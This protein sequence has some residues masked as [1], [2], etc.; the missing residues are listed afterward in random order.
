MAPLGRDAVIRLAVEMEEEQLRLDEEEARANGFAC[1]ED[2][3]RSET[4]KLLMLHEQMIADHCAA[5]GQTRE[6]ADAVLWHQNESPD[7]SLPPCQDHEHPFE[8]FCPHSL[9]D[10]RSQDNPGQI[11]FSRFQNRLNPEEL[12]IKE[13]DKS[14][15]LD[16]E[17]LEKY[18]TRDSPKTPRKIPFW[19]SAEG[20][21][22]YNFHQDTRPIP[23]TSPS[24]SLSQTPGLL[25]DEPTGSPLSAEDITMTSTSTSS[26]SDPGHSARYAREIPS[27]ESSILAPANSHRRNLGRKAQVRQ[28]RKPHPKTT[29]RVTSRPQSSSSGITKARWGPAMGLR[30]RT[31]NVFY[32]LALDGKTIS[33]AF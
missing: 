19:A 33:S 28:R 9:I 17:T 3:A 32:Q 27:L 1:Y 24:P 14:N 10:Y 11:A 13:D 8:S 29:L 2:Y 30:S 15:R 4:G 20:V 31:V 26:D 16:Q 12:N 25:Y 23:P 21:V 22:Q 18:W 6:Q 5:T 7:S